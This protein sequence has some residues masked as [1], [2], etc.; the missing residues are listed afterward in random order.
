M[1]GGGGF[2]FSDFVLDGEERLLRPSTRLVFL[3]YSCSSLF[4]GMDFVHDP[5]VPT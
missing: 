1:E 2:F 4:S 3:G 5:D